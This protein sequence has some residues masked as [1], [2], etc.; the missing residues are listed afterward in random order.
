LADKGI[1]IIEPV[2]LPPTGELTIFIDLGLTA[3]VF[4]N[5]LSNAL[6]YCRPTP[7]ENAPDRKHISYGIEVLMQE[8]SATRSALKFTLFNTGMPISQKGR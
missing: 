7:D 3:Q 4:A 1:E 2:G 5:L 6:K 8:P